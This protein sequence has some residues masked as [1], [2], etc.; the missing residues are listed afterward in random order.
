ML[1]FWQPWGKKRRLAANVPFVIQTTDY[2]VPNI[3]SE[4]RYGPKCSVWG[5][6]L[7]SPGLGTPF[8]QAPK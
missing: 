2:T 6:V 5:R 1:L 4:E 7:S 8:T 3:R